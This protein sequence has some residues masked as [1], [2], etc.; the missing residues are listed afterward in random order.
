[1]IEELSNETVWNLI[2]FYFREDFALYLLIAGLVISFILSFAVGANDSANSWGTSVGSGTVSLGWAYVLGSIM[3]IIGCTLLSGDVIKKVVQGIIN[4][5]AYKSDRNATILNGTQAG[6][7]DEFSE[8]LGEEKLLGVGCIAVMLGSGIWQLIASFFKWPVSGTHCIIFGLL[9]FTVTAKGSEGIN[10]VT[11]LIW[12]IVVLFISIIVAMFSTGLVYFPLYK[13]CIRSGSP[14]HGKNRIIF[15]SL[16]GLSIGIPVAFI[17]LQTNKAYGIF[18]EIDF[19]VSSGPTL[20]SIG[21][22]LLVS[23]VVGVLSFAVLLPYLKNVQ[24]DLALNFD[25]RCCKKKEDTTAVEMGDEVELKVAGSHKPPV[26]AEPVSPANEKEDREVTR[27]FR[28]LQ[29]VSAMTSALVHG[30]ND[31]ANCIGPFVVVVF[32]YQDGIIST[33]AAKAPP[34]V[35]LWG[36]IGIAIGLILFGKGVILTVGSGI[37]EMTS[38]RGF[39]VEWMAS[40]VGLVGTAAGFPLSTTHCKVGGVIGAGLVQGLV[41]TGSPKE[42]LK[43]VNFKVLSGVILSWVLTIPFA[44]GLSSLMFIILKELLI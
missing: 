23:V 24:S 31:V 33:D 14:F 19:A 32:I 34:L 13:Y 10:D 3:E 8:Y 41:E 21:A 12:I 29:V 16:T 2:L 7:F 38:S 27:I 5:D 39:V 28:P 4:I 35:S 43:F 44:F 9:G 11:D 36:G 26:P 30:G 37:S 17:I 18:S 42:A 15:A 40:L 20:I 1:M 22:G 6:N 25:P